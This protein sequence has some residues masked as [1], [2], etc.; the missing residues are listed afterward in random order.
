MVIVVTGVPGT[1]KTEI[2]IAI[3]KRMKLKYVDVNKVVKD[4]KLIE[5]YDEERKTNVVDEKKLVKILV[6]M[7]K[8]DKNL[9]IDS[10]L[11]HEIPSEYVELCVVTKCELKELQKRLKKRGYI[12]EKVRENMD[13][14]IFDLC[15]NEAKEKGHKLLIIDT[16]GKKADQIVQKLIK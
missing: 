13:A 12:P 6:E 9:V 5:S 3:A 11:A 7:I 8:K 10:H 4:H 14:E 1:G 15:L 2:A 16:T